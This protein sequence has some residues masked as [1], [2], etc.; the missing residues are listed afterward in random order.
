MK[1]G[2]KDRKKTEH[3]TVPSFLRMRRTRTPSVPGQRAITD[4]KS[5]RHSSTMIWA[6]HNMT[7]SPSTPQRV[8]K[9]HKQTGRHWMPSLVAEP[10]GFTEL[11]RSC[12]RDTSR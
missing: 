11:E 9:V 12:R 1:K 8:Y 2:R 10:S 4:V 3:T 6:G 5:W 7:R